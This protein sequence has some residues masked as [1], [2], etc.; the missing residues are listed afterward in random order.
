MINI[1]AEHLEQEASLILAEAQQYNIV[2]QEQFNAV[3]EELR[4]IKGVRKQVDDLFDTIIKKAHE[5]HKEAIGSKKK[6]TDPLDLAEKSFKKSMLAYQQEQ[7]RIARVEQERLRI[8][9]EEK[10]R[11]ER[12]KLEAKAMREIEKGNEEKAETLMEQAEELVPF[13]T[14]VAPQ[15]EKV[16]GISTKKTWK[17]RVTNPEQVPA[18]IN[19]MEIRTINQS[20]LDKMAKMSSGTIK[21]PGVEFYQESTLA[22]SA[23]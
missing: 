18:Y 21:V 10:A 4:R 6:L 23:R 13:I 11:K 3:G 9:A 14:V 22:V 1:N 12:E 2:N 16:S 20:Q 8:A 19:G 15:F 7:E 5:A 17:A